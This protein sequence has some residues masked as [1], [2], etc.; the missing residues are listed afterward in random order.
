M[1]SLEMIIIALW[2]LSLTVGFSVM[3]EFIETIREI[4]GEEKTHVGKR[5]R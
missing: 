2:V 1:K 5:G 4:W 3:H